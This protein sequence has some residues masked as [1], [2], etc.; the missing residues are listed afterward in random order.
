MNYIW[1]TD[2]KRLRATLSF[3]GKT[4]QVDGDPAEKFI[5]AESY[6]GTRQQRLYIHTYRLIYLFDVTDGFIELWDNDNPDP[7]LA[8]VGIV[9]LFDIAGKTSKA[10]DV[11]AADNNNP[12]ADVVAKWEYYPAWMDDPEKTE[13][14]AR[15]RAWYHDSTFTDTELTLETLP[16]HPETGRVMTTEEALEVLEAVRKS[17]EKK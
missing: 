2:N 10:A 13:R 4:I 15:L 7:A 12:L 8:F 9:R 17:L 5:L 14:H 3:D 1:T 11:V 16:D 6:Y